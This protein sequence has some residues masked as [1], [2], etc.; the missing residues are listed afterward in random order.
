MTEPILFLVG[1]THRSA[2]FAFREKIALGAETEAALAADLKRSSAVREFVTLNTC[3]RVEIYAVG[4]HAGAAREIAARFC[5]QRNVPVRDFEEFGFVRRDQEVVEHLCQVASGLDSQILGETE[6]F[7]QVKRAYATAQIRQTAGPILNRLFQKTFQ[8]AKHVR[9]N[10]GITTGH[11]SVANVAVDLAESVFGRIESTRLL[12]IGAG[13]MAEKGARAFQSRGT[14]S[15]DVINRRLERGA[16][17]AETLHA[18]SLPFEQREAALVAA[19]IVVCSTSSPNTILSEDAVRNAMRQRRSRPLLLIDLAM[20]RDIDAA[21][22]KLE[23]VFL[24][25]LDDLALVAAKNRDARLA[26][27]EAGRAALTQRT[28]ALWS[29]LQMQIATL[30]GTRNVASPFS[31]TVVVA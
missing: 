3:N 23:N 6:I 30:P 21:A 11:V 26:E 8:A 14:Q 27:A 15:I 7:G 9:A 31:P 4:T 28:H 13:E 22:G 17:L 29:Q 1:A 12:V 18:R 24:Y 20:P 19:D 25:N 5:A 2:P 16:A 10:T